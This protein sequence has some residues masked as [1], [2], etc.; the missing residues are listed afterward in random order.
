MK[1]YDKEEHEWKKRQDRLDALYPGRKRPSLPFDYLSAS[2]TLG[3]IA[4]GMVLI[5]WL[6][7]GVLPWPF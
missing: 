7:K 2:I 4:G 5:P 3:L 6:T 1:D